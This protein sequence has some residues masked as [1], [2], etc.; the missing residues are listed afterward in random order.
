VIPLAALAD[1]AQV[2][3]IWKL[4]LEFLIPELRIPLG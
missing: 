4:W 2:A 3:G 1:V